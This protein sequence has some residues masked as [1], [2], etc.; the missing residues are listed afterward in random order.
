MDHRL[1]AKI[2]TQRVT[3]LLPYGPANIPEGCSPAQLGAEE[4]VQ[5]V[6]FNQEYF[7]HKKRMNV[8]HNEETMTE[9]LEKN[10]GWGILSR[11]GNC[12]V[13]ASIG[14]KLLANTPSVRSIIQMQLEREDDKD[15]H[16]FVVLSKMKLETSSFTSIISWDSENVVICDPW[17]SCIQI[18]HPGLTWFMKFDE[19]ELMGAYQPERFYCHMDD[20]KYNGKLSVLRSL[21]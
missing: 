20:L 15:S 12:D 9:Y 10:V 1:I 17:L 13:M 19:H 16:T 6:R 11:A 21:D 18:N 7:I 5:Q 14:Y 8:S 3:E 2:V 4:R